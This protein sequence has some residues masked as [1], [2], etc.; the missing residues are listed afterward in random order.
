MIITDVDVE[1]VLLFYQQQYFILT[2]N[3]HISVFVHAIQ[4]PKCM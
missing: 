4:R 2:V 1:F 3:C